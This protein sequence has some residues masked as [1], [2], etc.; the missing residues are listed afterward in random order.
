MKILITGTAGFI[1][2]HLAKSLALRGD[3]VV[4]VDSINDYYDKRV[5]Y[6]RLVNSGIIQSIKDGEPIPYN[7][8]I[9]SKKSKNY[10]FVKMNLADKDNLFKLFKEEKFD[11]V[12]NLA[13]QAGV[14]Y[15]L[16]NPAAYIQSNIIGFL[17]IL[18][19][20]RHFDVKNLTFA[21]S[22]SVYGL[23]TKLPFSTKDNVDHPISF[24]AASKK[25]NELMAHTYSH[26]FGIRTTGLRFFTVYGPW[27][28]PDMALFLFVKAALE[29]LPIDVFN[30]GNMKRDFTY[31]DDCIKGIVKVID[32]PVMPAKKNN[33]NLD[34]PSISSAPYKIYNIGNNNPVKLMDFIKAIEKK[35]GK[36]LKKIFLPLQ[37]GDVPATYADVTDLEADFG[38]KPSTSVQEG[39]DRFVDWYNEFFVI[40]NLWLEGEYYKLKNHLDLDVWKKSMDLVESIYKISSNFPKDEMYALTS[41]IR[42]ASVSIPSNIAE[43]SARNGNKEFIQF[44]YIS[45]GS[46]SE[47]ETQLMI[48]Q[49]L[50]YTVNIGKEL[51]DIVA[52][53]KMLS[54]LIKYLKGK[55]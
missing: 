30:N 11:A 23:N 28:R 29:N 52:I 12:C 27:G 53:K 42:R 21:S 39:I 40:R 46:V 45:L 35:L 13:A 48:A 16:K 50:K 3:K 19:G 43:G 41:Q 44:L 32:N 26:L 37:A 22:S 14:R 34:D 24:Y 31:I 51:K 4:G 25:S 36:T 2:F 6:G 49:R 7:Q 8:K 33:E 47:V 20:C 1:G 15:S 38:Y 18:E 10:C 5:K 55:K 9:V 17:N 54:G